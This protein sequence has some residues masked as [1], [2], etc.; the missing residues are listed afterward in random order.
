MN[1]Q[2]KVLIHE[3]LRSCKDI[4][5]HPNVNT[6]TLVLSY[7]DFIKFLRISGNEFMYEN[8]T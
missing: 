7:N 5:F 6:S 2:V 1:K 4:T 8:I 3:S